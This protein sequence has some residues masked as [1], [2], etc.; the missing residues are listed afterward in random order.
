MEEDIKDPQQNPQIPQNTQ[1][2]VQPTQRHNHNGVNS[3]RLD[4]KYFLGF[5]NVQVADATVAPTYTVQNGTIIF[6]YDATHWRMWV[7][8]AN[9]WKSATLS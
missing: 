8:L 1:D 7:R 4:P 3:P 6:Q 5:Q 2:T 9:V